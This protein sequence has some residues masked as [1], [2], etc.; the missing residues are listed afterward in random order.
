[1]SH[2]KYTIIQLC[3]VECGVAAVVH[4][5]GYVDQ[6]EEHQHVDASDVYSQS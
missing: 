4:M 1:M 5:R 3:L 6:H 2:Y